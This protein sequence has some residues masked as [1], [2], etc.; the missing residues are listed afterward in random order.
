MKLKIQEKAINLR[1]QP[2]EIASLREKKKL[3]QSTKFPGNEITILLEVNA[4]ETVDVSFNEN[5]FTFSFPESHLEEW[6]N[7]KKIGL[8][9]QLDKVLVTIEMDLPRRTK[10]V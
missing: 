5:T 1:L 6:G 8:S 7:S 3:N 10:K 9:H 4:R 2:E